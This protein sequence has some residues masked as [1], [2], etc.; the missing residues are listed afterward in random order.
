MDAL[1]IPRLSAVSFLVVAVFTAFLLPACGPK[2]EPED[3]ADTKKTPPK[4]KNDVKPTVHPEKKLKLEPDPIAEKI[5]GKSVT[6][7]M[8][9]NK[10]GVIV[11]LLDH[12]ATVSSVQTPDRDGKLGEITL[13][14][15]DLKTYGNNPSYFGC[16]VGRFANRIANGRFTIDGTEY[17]LTTNNGPKDEEG[18]FEHTLHGGK[19][20]FAH[21]PWHAEPQQ[22]PDS[23]GVKFTLISPDGDQGFPGQ[24]VAHVTYTLTNDNELKIEYQAN[25][26][27]PTHINLTNHCYWNLAGGGDVLKH[28]LKL[29]SDKFVA[30][31]DELIPT[32]ELKAV[33]GTPWDFTSATAIG[34][35]IDDEQLGK[36]EAVGRGYDHCYV[37]REGIADAKTRVALVAEVY[38]PKTGRVM[39]VSTDQ[40]GVQL[41]TGNFL[42]GSA[43]SGGAKQ[44]GAF[45]LECQQFPDA[46]NQKSFPSSLL[47]PKETYVQTT[48]HKFSVRK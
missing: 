30:V 4:K 24:V 18:N 29:N 5:G 15:K 32:G 10:H 34:K 43:N 9:Q 31:N 46:P 38:D 23:V 33:Q 6:Q 25:T 42:D 39:T 16:T 2:S 19:E 11:K 37:I 44:H 22:G 36:P 35:R 13:A 21:R 40:P 14:Y 12:G 47:K 28:E 8:L 41:Y 7:Y 48:I 45:C 1:R 3:D 17:K 20:G 26:N 27:K